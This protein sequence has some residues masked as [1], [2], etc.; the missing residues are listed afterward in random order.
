MKKVISVL[1]C[2]TLIV[3]AFTGTVFAG[4]D[5]GGNNKQ[6]NS[7]WNNGK[8]SNQ[9][10]GQSK[11]QLEQV[12]EFK[13]MKNHWG[14]KSVENVQGLGIFGGYDDGTFQPDKALTQAELAVIIDRLLQLKNGDDED[15]DFESLVNWGGKGDSDIPGWAKK[16]VMKGFYKKYF[17]LNRFH[18]HVQ[19]DRLTACV[20]LAKALDLDPITEYKMNPF[21]DLG[22]ISDE[23][24]GY[25]LAL[26][27]EGYINGYPNGVFNPYSFLSRAQ[28]AVIIEKLV[29]ELNEDLEEDTDE[30]SEDKTAPEWSKSSSITA[31]AIKTNSVELKWSGAKDDVKVVGYKVIYELDGSKKTKSVTEKSVTITGLEAATEYTF[32]VEAKDAAG[33]WSDDGP[34][35]EVTTLEED[36]DEEDKEAPA[37][38]KDASLTVSRAS[39]EIVTLVWPDAED[40][41][42]VA[43]YKIYK[44]GEL[45][46]TVDDDV[47]SV[48][49]SGIKADTEYTFKVKAVDKS[50]N[51]STSL[52]K[53]YLSE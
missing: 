16:S 5:N 42:K 23:D 8:S 44:N 46:K 45:V 40:N 3:S 1:V 6:Q 7:S 52:S 32:T 51:V 47:N 35:V 13:D 29:G 4:Q 28:M 19:V 48:N 22:L 9:N 20:A 2:A 33:N 34:S 31:T 12:K 36:T 26:Y 43:S 27:Q 25:L 38:P 50:G 30:D 21:T 10:W 18:S 11:K 24:Y 53:N 14:K 37:W 15:K 39:A 41:D 49:L 17:N